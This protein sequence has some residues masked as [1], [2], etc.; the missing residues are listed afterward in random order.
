MSRR[1]QQSAFDQIS[2]FDRG[3][4]VAYR[5]YGLTFREIA[6]RV[7]R[8]QTTLMRICNRWMQ[9]GTTTRRGPQ[10]TT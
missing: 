8:N 9:E 5:D 2:E 3:R 10:C 7:K 4:I 6:S 1:K